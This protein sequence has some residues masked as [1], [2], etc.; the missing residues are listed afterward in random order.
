[1]PHSSGGD[2]MTGIEIEKTRVNLFNA[3]GFLGLF[4]GGVAAYT[5]T[6]NRTDANSE[7][8]TALVAELRVVKTQIA[9]LDTYAFRQGQVEEQVKNVNLRADRIVESFNNKMDNLTQTVTKGFTSLTSDLAG[10]KS[11]I[12]VINQ[13]QGIKPVPG[14]FRQP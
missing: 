5:T 6:T 14:V 1:M 2:D 4:A 10:V 13:Q 7:A 12:R 11:D 3:L 8:I 9:P